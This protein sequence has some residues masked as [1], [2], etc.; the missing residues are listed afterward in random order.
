MELNEIIADYIVEEY[1]LTIFLEKS[2]HFH[3]AYERN[4]FTYI[5]H[6]KN[7]NTQLDFDEYYQDICEINNE[8]KFLP[9]ICLI[10]EFMILFV[11]MK[12]FNFI[13]VK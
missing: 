4:I 1:E 9:V 11:Q 12:T 8:T 6:K 5:S 3:Y 13:I 2:I 10:K 7:F